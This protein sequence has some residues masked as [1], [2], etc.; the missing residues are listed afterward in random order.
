MD[1]PAF[2]T[3]ALQ[4]S[5]VTFI[6]DVLFVIVVVESVLTRINCTFV[7]QL[8]VK[9]NFLHITYCDL[10]HIINIGHIV[11]LR[12]IQIENFIQYSDLINNRKENE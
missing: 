10:G 5:A 6:V 4:K 7:E 8:K 3:M 11:R 9:L 1:S 2:G 12:L